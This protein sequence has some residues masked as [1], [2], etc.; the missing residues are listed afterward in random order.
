MFV[1]S[2]CVRYGD[3]RDG[4]SWRA[5]ALGAGQAWVGSGAVRAAARYCR[6]ADGE[7]VGARGVTPRK[8]MVPEIARVLDIEVQEVLD[9]MASSQSRL[10]GVSLPVRPLL[11]ELPLG[12]LAE[13]VFERFSTDLAA[14]VYPH[15]D[16]VHGYGSRGHKQGGIDVEVRHPEGVPTGIQC[17]R[18]REFGPTDVQDAVKAL[19]LEVRECIIFL[20][21]VASPGARQEIA[22]YP[23]WQLCDA[24]DISRMVRNLPDQVAAIR[25]VE[26]YFLGYREAF[27]GI[28]KPSPW[29]SAEA[30]FRPLSGNPVFTHDW[31]LV[32]RTRN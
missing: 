26:T 17:K 9:A 6:P 8:A 7:P 32:G 3:H 11:A 13:D 29:E 10:S 19:T 23:G 12:A 20:S 18:A 25:L 5:S 30:F 14:L 21:R 22:K 4:E 28:A 1:R 15:P 16:V 2:Y 31:R 24:L 27:F